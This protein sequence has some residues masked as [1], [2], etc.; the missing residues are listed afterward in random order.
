MDN[1]TINCPHCKDRIECS[2]A[3]SEEMRMSGRSPTLNC[4]NCGVD[5]TEI[6]LKA[7][8]DG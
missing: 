2:Q 3:T 8:K 7:L 5:I 6:V 1:I 4:G